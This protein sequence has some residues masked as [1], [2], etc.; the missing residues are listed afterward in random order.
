MKKISIISPIY[1]EEDNIAPFISEIDEAV[2]D[3]DYE[4]ILVDDGS[5][6][7]SWE[8]IK[9]QASKNYRIKAI[10]FRRNSGQTQAIRA[11]IKKASGQFIVLI[12]ADLQND[13]KDI[14][15]LYEEINKGYDLVSG[16]RFDRKDDFF[17][18][19]LP[20]KIA[21]WIISAI[22]GI[23][24]HDYGCSLK[25]YRSEFLKDIELYGEMHRFLPALVGYKGAK[26]S[27]IKV[28]HRPRLS[29]NSK[30]G[31][32]R[33]FKVIVDLITVKF[34]GD[35]ML[36]PAYFFGGISLIFISISFI[37]S[38]I[39]L[40]YKWYNG[41][42]VKDQPLF[43]VAIFLAL[44]GVQIGLIGLIAEMLMRIYYNSGDKST[45]SIKEEI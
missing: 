44:I 29:G 8:I 17:K 26:I 43:L 22:T 32:F 21:N 16:W 3:L 18:R 39:T 37:F 9:N 25:I 41:I 34:L 38:L 45:Y 36:K 35:F 33:I 28:N 7:S 11:G 13:P 31:L 2:K 24:L 6:D 5:N 10:R 19:V 27:E 23:K 42:F 15:K 1:N 40:Y 12:D 30:Y 14:S 4:L 20:S